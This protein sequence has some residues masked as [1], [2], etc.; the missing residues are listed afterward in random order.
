[1]PEATLTP[2]QARHAYDWLAR[3][4]VLVRHYENLATDRQ[5]GRVG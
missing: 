1:M 3:P 4:L 5:S 2:D